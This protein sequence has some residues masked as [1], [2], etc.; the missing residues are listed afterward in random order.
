MEEF[1]QVDILL[2]EDNP[3]DAELTM[4]GLAAQKVANSITWVKDGAE[5]LDY[6]FRR[7]EYADRK[8]NGPRL[9][10][11]PG[12]E[13]R[14]LSNCCSFQYCRSGL[15]VGIFFL[16]AFLALISCGSRVSSGI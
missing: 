5:A 3:L 16:S 2:V 6:V 15:R 8:G 10:K 1:D 9:I 12:G 13:F 7:G 14:S 11:W 4:R